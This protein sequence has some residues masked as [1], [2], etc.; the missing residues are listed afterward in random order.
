MIDFKTYSPQLKAHLETAR[1]E[2]F[3]HYTSPEAL[4]G[5]LANKEL[6]ASNTLFLNDSLEVK[7]GIQVAQELIEQRL[8][9]ETDIDA[10]DFMDQVGTA[11]EESRAFK[12]RAYVISFTELEDALSQWRGYCPASGGYVV[13]LPTAQVT[14]MAN[15]QGFEL[16][17]CIY[18]I[19]LQRYILNEIIS[20]AIV[21]FKKNLEEGDGPDSIVTN[22]DA[23]FDYLLTVC[24]TMKHF[25]FAEEQ[26]WRLILLRDDTSTQPLFFRPSYKGVIPYCKFSLLNHTYPYLLERDG[27]EFTVRIGPSPN[28]E[29]RG[30]AVGMM[31][32]QYLG[33]RASAVF[34]DTAPLFSS[35]P[36][37]TW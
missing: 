26:E 35:V 34:S 9:T 21:A 14:D 33:I 30:V 28:K 22:S 13:G 4:I 17:K 23:F 10:R 16:V 27:V 19:D 36:Y 2:R 24:S 20:A 31:L 3:Y 15:A 5:I 18:G 11:I 1:P 32:G 29:E 8:E 12:K 37:Q 7:H 6:W 25:S